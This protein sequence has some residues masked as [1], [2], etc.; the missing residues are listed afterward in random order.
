MNSIPPAIQRPQISAIRCRMRLERHIA[1]THGCLAQVIDAV[2][3]MRVQA[4]VE[5]LSGIGRK[6]GK[7]TAHHELSYGVI[8]PPFSKKYKTT[9]IKKGDEATTII[10]KKHTR[11]C[12]W[13][14]MD[15]AEKMVPASPVGPP[16]GDIPA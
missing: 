7:Y 1:G 15:V 2:Q 3:E 11:Q 13:C 6:S 12:S 16:G 8:N 9:G 10:K 4:V 5:G 14:V